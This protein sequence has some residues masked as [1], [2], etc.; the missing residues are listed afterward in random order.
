MI[1]RWWSISL[2]L[3]LSTGCAL[4]PDVRLQNPQT[5]Q[6]VT[7]EGY[8]AWAPGQL[9]GRIATKEARDACVKAREAEGYV[10]TK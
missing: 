3:T 5:G 2:V 6:T 4:T 8:S 1:P 7:C 9:W 10:V